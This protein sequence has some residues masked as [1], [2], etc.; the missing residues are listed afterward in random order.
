M[1]KG[2]T[3]SLYEEATYLYI[4]LLSDVQLKDLP[5]THDLILQTLCSELDKPIIIENNDL[6][7]HVLLALRFSNGKDMDLNEI[8]ERAWVLERALEIAVFRN[9]HIGFVLKHI[10][11]IPWPEKETIFI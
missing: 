4:H 11:E 5:L 10:R 1:I 9:H 8:V 6:L 2:T 3:A 7:G